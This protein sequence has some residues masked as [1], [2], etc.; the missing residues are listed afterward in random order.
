MPKKLQATSSRFVESLSYM[1][2]NSPD[3]SRIKAAGSTWALCSSF[4]RK[5]AVTAT[6]KLNL[7]HL[8]TWHLFTQDAAIGGYASKSM[9]A[10]RRSMLALARGSALIQPLDSSLYF[11]WQ[12]SMQF[13]RLHSVAV[14]G[15]ASQRFHAV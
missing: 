7:C 13:V 6:G 4:R 12:E 10:H 14:R 15:D 1:H 3:V 9:K 5:G 8:C 11:S 2:D